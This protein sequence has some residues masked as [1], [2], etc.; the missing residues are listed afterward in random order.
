MYAV[1]SNWWNL[2]KQWENMSQLRKVRQHHVRKC[3]LHLTLNIFMVTANRKR[4]RCGECNGCKQSNCGNCSEC[5]DMK[6]FGGPGRKKKACSM[7]KC[8]AQST[9]VNLDDTISRL[10]SLVHGTGMYWLYFCVWSL[11]IN[12]FWTD[13][14]PQD[15]TGSDEYKRQLLKVSVD[16]IFSNKYIWP[17]FRI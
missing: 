4:T 1:S 14:T 5:L 7:R 9:A 8:T 3:I 11:P 6:E 16:C 12:F 2:R 17:M 15:N 10:T 13:I